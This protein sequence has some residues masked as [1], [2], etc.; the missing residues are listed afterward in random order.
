MKLFLKPYFILFVLTYFLIRLLR[1]LE[2]ELPEVINS[3]LT[4]FLF[5]PILLTVSLVGVRK[6]KRDENIKLTSAMVIVSV[7][8]VSV[9]FEFIMPIKSPLFVGDYLDIVAYCLGA[10]FF[11]WIHEKRKDS[12]LKSFN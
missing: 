2:L 7:I 12:V 11:Y 1:F 6:L 4:D 8:F 9:V 3:H 5:M 10:L